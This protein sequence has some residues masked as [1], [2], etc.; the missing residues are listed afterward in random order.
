[1]YWVA[2]Q[3][4]NSKI[5]WSQPRGINDKGDVVGLACWPVEEPN[6]PDPDHSGANWEVFLYTEE[7]GT[8]ENLNDIVGDD[9]PF[10]WRLIDAGD[11]NNAGLIVGTAEYRV[12]RTVTIDGVPTLVVD[13][14][15]GVFRYNPNPI[16]GLSVIEIFG[17]G[18]GYYWEMATSINDFGDMLLQKNFDSGGH[19]HVIPLSGDPIEIP[20]PTGGIGVWKANAIN[21]SCW[22]AGNARI[23]DYVNAVRYTPAGGTVSLGWLKSPG[24][25]RLGQAN[26]I[27]DSGQVTGWTTTS[28]GSAG[29]A[30]RYTDGTG[31]KDLGAL[32]TSSTKGYGINNAGYV[33]GDAMDGRA[34][35]YT[36]RM[37][38]LRAAIDS[39]PPEYA[40]M[41]MRARKI[42]NDGWILG[43]FG[44]DRGQACL[45]VPK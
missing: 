30:F 3:E 13:Q 20:A 31:M 4:A 10:G 36:D 9:L 39:L 33:V 22:I 45:L 14:D 27:N 12:E 32:G 37:V 35:V 17:S 42:N 7:D 21:K 6:D 41:Q 23:G 40:Q 8:T 16:E 11:I 2:G 24:T 34:F 26:D 29:H 43:S 1:L 28:G 5:E 19:P 15:W 18:D 38:D 44:G 25:D